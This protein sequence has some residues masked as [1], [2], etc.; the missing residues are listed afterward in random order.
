MKACPCVCDPKH[1]HNIIMHGVVLLRRRRRRRRHCWWHFSL[2][3]LISLSHMVSSYRILLPS[4][5]SF[6]EAERNPHTHR[7]LRT[8]DLVH[9]RNQFGGMRRS[10]A[11]E[12]TS[13]L[14]DVVFV[15]MCAVQSVFTLYR[16]VHNETNALRSLNIAPRQRIKILFRLSENCIIMIK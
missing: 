4:G 2:Q 9:I 7:L 3:F 15:L 16:G 5:W 11:N 6:Y 14:R 8:H 12:P 1:V 10:G 13:D